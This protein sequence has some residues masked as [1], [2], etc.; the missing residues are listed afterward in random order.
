M[1]KEVATPRGSVTTKTAR[2]TLISQAAQAGH[3]IP[4]CH[5]GKPMLPSERLRLCHMTPLAKGGAD[6][7]PNRVYGHELCELLQTGEDVSSIRKGDRQGGGRGSQWERRKNGKTQK[8]PAKQ[9]P[10]PPKGTRKLLSRKM[11]K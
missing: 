7:F 5:C 11:R 4:C 1:G 10:W 2:E 8:I 3:P 6:T 9:N